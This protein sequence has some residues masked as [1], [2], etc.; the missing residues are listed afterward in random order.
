MK[1]SVHEDRKQKERLMFTEQIQCVTYFIAVILF[2]LYK[3]FSQEMKHVLPD[4]LMRL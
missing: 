4:Q 2:Q 1:Y 3:E